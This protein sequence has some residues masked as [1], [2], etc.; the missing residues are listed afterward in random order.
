MNVGREFVRYAI[1]ADPSTGMRLQPKIYMLFSTIGGPSPDFVLGELYADR[2][3]DLYRDFVADETLWKQK[4][5][6]KYSQKN[7]AL[8]GR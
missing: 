6:E 8:L 1:S 3:H 7:C 5:D 4:L 2:V